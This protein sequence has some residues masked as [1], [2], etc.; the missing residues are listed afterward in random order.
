MAEWARPILG[1]LSVSHYSVL[2]VGLWIQLICCIC[3]AAHWDLL[4]LMQSHLINILGDES[5]TGLINH[6]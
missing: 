2:G 6:S 5:V 1:A 4:A 3:S